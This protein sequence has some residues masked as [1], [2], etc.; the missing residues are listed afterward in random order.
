MCLDR[1]FVVFIRFSKIFRE[2][3]GHFL[4]TIRKG[5]GT[6]PDL[7]WNISGHFLDML[8]KLSATC[9]GFV[10]GNLLEKNKIRSGIFPESFTKS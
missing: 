1:A 9:P 2:L 5:S 4:D 10:S 6:N 7:F 3:S 8:L